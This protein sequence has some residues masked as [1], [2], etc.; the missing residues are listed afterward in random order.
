MAHQA[1]WQAE[2]ARICQDASTSDADKARAKQAII[3]RFFIRPVSDAVAAAADRGRGG[4]RA[5]K[6]AA[7]QAWGDADGGKGTSGSGSG[8]NVRYRNGVAVRVA[9]GEKV[10]GCSS[11]L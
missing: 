6:D 9:K 1:A 7:I 11:G 10:G 8:S 5:V 3:D 4:G 2:Q